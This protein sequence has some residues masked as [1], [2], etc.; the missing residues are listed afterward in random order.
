MAG[1]TITSID[2]S[3][4]LNAVAKQAL[5][6]VAL[7]KLDLTDYVSVG[8]KVWKTGPE[9]VLNSLSIV[10]GR[11][12]V[13]IRP[14][15]A[16]YSLIQSTEDV[17]TFSNQF[18]K[19]IF[20][21]KDA[22][23][24]GNV[25]TDKNP[26][27]LANGRDNTSSTTQGAEAV[28]TMWEQNQPI[29]A[30]FCFGGAEAWDFSITYYP[31][32][33]HQAF[34]SPN[35]FAVWWNGVITE[36]QNEI[37]L[38]QNAFNEMTLLNYIGGLYHFGTTPQ[39]QSGTD[40][41]MPG[42]AVNLTSAFNTKFGTQYTSAQLRT[43]Y[44]KDFL[45]FMVAEIKKY[46]NYLAEDSTEFQLDLYKTVGNVKHAHIDNLPKSEQ[47]IMLYKDL[48]IDAE[49]LVLPEIFN[50]EYLKMDNYEPVSYWQN[51]NNRTAI[52]VKANI[53]T[54]SGGAISSTQTVAD[55]ISISYVVGVMFD[56]NAVK[57]QFQFNS[58]DSTPLEARKRYV[59]TWYHNMK[60][61]INDFSCKGI[62]FYMADP[63]T[64]TEG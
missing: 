28:G 3:A 51:R 62:V 23:E 61:A 35:D 20:F 37:Q 38:A 44:I 47:M 52:S 24:A 30:E 25:N 41:F 57:T 8:E 39:T 26:A 59:N 29:C 63:V 7:S 36:K 33:L 53:P 22:Q 31:E 6:E 13:G 54:V 1:K 58:T 19:I 43:T 21:R 2:A 42:S 11:T 60:N 49:A 9:N 34:L 32:Q 64:P 40:Y 50:T 12:L 14:V 48:F 15:A 5:G 4:I 56:K 27:N 16:R 55:N 10:I 18:R 45:A 17:G 46:S